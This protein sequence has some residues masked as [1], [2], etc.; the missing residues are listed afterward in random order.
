M[1]NRH[2]FPVTAAEFEKIYSKIR[3]EQPKK[4]L[5]IVYEATEQAI[6]ALHGCRKYRN[7]QVYRSVATRRRKQSRQ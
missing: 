4:P 2:K 5:R 6:T 1:N 7:W 3:S